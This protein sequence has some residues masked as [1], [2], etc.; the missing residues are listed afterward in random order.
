MKNVYLRSC[1]RF[2]LLV[3]LGL[4]GLP[5]S[6][7]ARPQ[8][9]F[10][11]ALEKIVPGNWQT[12]RVG[13]ENF[14]E[15]EAM[16]GTVRVIVEEARSRIP[17]ASYA[18]PVTL[19]KGANTARVPV[20]VFVP[21]DPPVQFAVQLMEGRDDRGGIVTTQTF[22]HPARSSELTLLSVG[23][24]QTGAKFMPGATVR[25]QQGGNVLVPL[26]W[27][28]NSYSKTARSPQPMR[29]EPFPNPGDLPEHSSGYEPVNIVY[30]GSDVLPDALNNAQA[31][32]LRLWVQ[33]G[34][35]AVWAD[36]NRKRWQ[37]DPRFADFAGISPTV[38]AGLTRIGLGF[39]AR[40]TDAQ[41]TQATWKTLI[42]SGTTTPRVGYLLTNMDYWYGSS[43]AS[44]PLAGLGGGAPRP[45]LVGL[46]LVG[47]LLLLAP[48]NYLVL[49]RRDKREWAWATV[50]LLVLVFSVGAF[51][52]GRSK[53]GGRVLLS[54]ASLVEAGSG[55]SEASVQASAGVFAPVRGRYTLTLQA[56]NTLS[57]TLD[58]YSSND[59]EPLYT[60]TDTSRG[61]TEIRGAQIPMWGARTFEFHTASVAIGQG[62]TLNLRRTKTA[63]E[64][65]ITNQ[66]GSD[67]KGAYLLHQK[68]VYPLPSLPSGRV[69]PVR[70]VLTGTLKRLAQNPPLDAALL[71]QAQK[72]PQTEGKIAK[73]LVNTVSNIT[74][75]VTPD[76][77][78]VTLLAWL[79]RSP[80]PVLVD[81]QPI[82]GQKQATLLMVHGQSEKAQ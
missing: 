48:I 9:T 67:L 71:T 81:G 72:Q 34:G 79:H 4:A 3:F 19:G 42:E 43:F 70:I 20:T 58:R 15:D 52:W 12:V 26:T 11:P 18:A 66:T 68:E 28:Q 38:P 13:V 44:S 35:I 80:V 41:N 39:A 27:Q 32:A 16:T 10:T 6:A 21:S 82:A 1:F 74:Q 23:Q 57:R 69:T 73:Q 61:L 64:G 24:A 51:A 36:T 75:Q 17:L 2:A 37:A 33:S 40:I 45:L 59:N 22:T 25:V 8:L 31:V 62:V 53:N 29:V 55:R 54:V 63:W 56:P 60:Y 30:F 14:T 46:F 7:H 76:K 47:Y 77:R 50:P 49:K 65:T 78:S 5:L